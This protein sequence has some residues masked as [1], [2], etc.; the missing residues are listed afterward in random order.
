[1]P[2]GVCEG[3]SAETRKARELLPRFP[4]TL[5]FCAYNCS[6]SHHLAVPS[7]VGHV[8]NGLCNVMENNNNKL[9]FP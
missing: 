8:S 2:H 1:M 4:Q 5:S 9:R 6:V 7:D 3:S